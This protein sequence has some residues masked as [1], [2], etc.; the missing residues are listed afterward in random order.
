VKNHWFQ[1]LAFAFVVV[2]ALGCSAVN[3][4]KKEI[5]KTQQPKTL[6]GIDG[7][8]QITIPGG[9]RE[10]KQLNEKGVIQ[11]SN[12]LNEQYVLV[13]SNDKQDFA[14]SMT[15][16]GITKLLREDL[17][18]NITEAETTAPIPTTVNGYP[19]EQFEASGSVQGI[20]V[21]Y[22]YTVVDMPQNYYQILAW[23]LAS[24]FDANKPQLLEVVNS[25]QKTSGSDAF[26]VD[27]PSP[28]A[29]K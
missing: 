14:K 6:I 16:S 9:W 19:A 2:F 29:K 7:K 22:V 5:D 27:E 1:F 26:S 8:C 15:L 20:K 25:F 18:E 21:K 4:I 12:R 23:S 11:A 24:R 28:P 3:Q 10:D 13:M 17:S